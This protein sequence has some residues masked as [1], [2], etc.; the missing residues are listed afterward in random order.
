MTYR[1]EFDDAPRGG[2]LANIGPKAAFFIVLIA[3]SF[4]V[5]AVW[6]L[7]TGT[8]SGDVN[9]IPIVRADND[10]FKVKPD[11]PGGM[12]VRHKDSTLFGS[13]KKKDGNDAQRIENLL[14]EDENEEPMPRSQ[15]FAGLN[16]EEAP[17]LERSD[18]PTPLDQPV[19]EAPP[20]VPGIVQPFEE[21]LAPPE[22]V[23]EPVVEVAPE[24]T[25]EITPEPAPVKVTP[26]VE[27]KPAPKPVVVAKPK[28]APKPIHKK[29][30]VEVRSD[31]VP[32][33]TKPT[34]TVGGYYVQLAST[35]EKTKAEAEWKKLS[36]KYS[37]ITGAPHR[38][39]TAD[40]GAK[41]VYYRIQVGPMSRDEAQKK[42]AAIKKI[43]PNGCLVKK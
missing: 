28:P 41:G 35:K 14:A 37:V 7:Y 30:P 15:L 23:A 31:S 16:T 43:N 26:K 33:T 32:V 22:S 34:N 40:L 27:A 20:S 19:S 17:D 12:E 11:D 5:G 1:N 18:S 3:L 21:K 39:E 25:P 36:G 6:K 24:V 13:M 2:F 10:P 42:C 4:M 8:G 9:N 29:A 38:I